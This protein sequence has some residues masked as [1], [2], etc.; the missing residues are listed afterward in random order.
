MFDNRY[1]FKCDFTYFLKESDIKYVCTII[2]KTQANALVEQVHQIIY[3]MLIT[4][5]LYK[6]VFYYIYPWGGNLASLT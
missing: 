4:K 3:N 6:K 2:K 1:Y 5:G